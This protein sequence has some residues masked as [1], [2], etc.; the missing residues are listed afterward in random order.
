MRS[1]YSWWITAFQNESCSAGAVAKTQEKSRLFRK[2][3][4]RKLIVQKYYMEETHI[5]GTGKDE[6]TK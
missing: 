1:G 2:Y 5:P 3:R 6:I 4:I